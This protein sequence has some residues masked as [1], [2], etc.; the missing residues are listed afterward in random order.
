MFHTGDAIA[1]GPYPAETLDLL[2]SEPKIEC[3]MGNHEAYFVEG[4]PQPRPEW[5]SEGGCS[6]A[7]DA[8]TAGK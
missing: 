7:M 6:S 1:I 4:L 2:L 8:P 5:M 3:V